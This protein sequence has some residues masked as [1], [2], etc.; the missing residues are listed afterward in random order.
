[1]P[2]RDENRER[3]NAYDWKAGGEEWTPDE[4]WRKAVVSHAIEPWV[5]EGSSVLEIGPGGGRWTAELLARRP[6]RLIG[7]DIA[8]ACVEQCA[9][10]FKDESAAEFHLGNGAD[11]GM[12]EDES[13]DC[14]WSFDVFVHIERPEVAAYFSE[15]RRVMKPDAC[16]V[17]HYASIDRATGDDARSGWR[18][19]FTSTDMGDILADQ[20]FTLIEDYYDPDISEAN[21]S[22]VI[23]RA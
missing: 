16:G 6:G 1:M 12:V 2:T 8:E 17:V 21:S 18:A 5:A 14:V 7:V 10:R 13:V 9:E 20:G 22:V 19:D 3:W 15:F 11:L 4:T 23:W